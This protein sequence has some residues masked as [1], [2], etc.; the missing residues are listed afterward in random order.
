MQ[1]L[2]IE[3]QS[4]PS[5]GSVQ[6]KLSG[7]TAVVTGA[8]QGIGKAIATRFGLEG[9]TVVAVDRNEETL[10]GL[11]GLPG[12][13]PHCMDVS[14]PQDIAQC[15]DLYPDA[16][17]LV[18]C[19]GVVHHGPLLDCSPEDFS[20]A[21]RINVESIFHMTRTYMPGMLERED[22]LIVNIASAAA[23][24]KSAENRFAYA[25]SKGAVVALT[26]SIAIDYIGRGV[27]CNSISPGT[28][29]TPSLQERI[30]AAGNS[31]Q[32]YRDFVA[33]QPMG[34]LGQPEEVAAVALMMASGE[35]N[36][37]SGSDV[38]IDGGFSL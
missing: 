31:E 27:R 36:F 5:E 4:Q 2:H 30:A 9:A 1:T 22:G 32:A 13:V 19:V 26:K 18:N 17:I 25:T 23:A 33:R 12:I 29:Y 6:Q 20:Q 10:A 15:G 24:S 11:D 14:K 34:R 21:M 8:G 37:M 35:A 7:K 3:N 16:D 38:V 28:I